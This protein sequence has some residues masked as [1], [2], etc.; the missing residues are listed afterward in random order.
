MSND[1]YGATVILMALASLVA[2]GVS[3]HRVDTD[4]ICFVGFTTAIRW[5]VSDQRLRRWKFETAIG[6]FCTLLI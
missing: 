4:H 2:I 1:V 5:T 3:R 6:V